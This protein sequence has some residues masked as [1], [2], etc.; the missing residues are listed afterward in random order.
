MREEKVNKLPQ[1]EFYNDNDETITKK[2]IPFI[3]HPEHVTFL[4]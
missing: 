4:W 3:I 2:K 1:D